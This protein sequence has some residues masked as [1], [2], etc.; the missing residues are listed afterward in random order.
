[1]P[2]RLLSPTA[3]TVLRTIA[4]GSRYGFDLVDATG[5]PSGTIYPVLARL[6]EQ[7]LVRSEWEP[8]RE[9]RKAKRPPRRYYE[10]TERGRAVFVEAAERYAS[11]GRSARQAVRIPPVR[12]PESA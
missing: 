7:G 9:A 1:M 2:P 11:L 4:L 12:G 6:E 10:I 3:L 8:R 5:L